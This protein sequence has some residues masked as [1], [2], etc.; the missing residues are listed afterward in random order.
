MVLRIDATRA[1]ASLLERLLVG[2]YITGQDCVRLS[3]RGGLSLPQRAA[4]RSV[5]DRLLGMTI[6]VDTPEVVEVENFIDP[7]R[8]EVPRLIHRVAEVLRRELKVC[9][10]VLVTGR[11]ELLER[12]PPMEAE[13]DQLTLLVTRQLLLSSDDS[14]IAR[15]IDVPSRHYQFGYRL[16]AK[17]LEVI[18][19]RIETIAGELH[20]HLSELAAAPPGAKEALRAGLPRFERLLRRSMTAFAAV[21]VTEADALLNQIEQARTALVE[22][23]LRLL[24]EEPTSRASAAAQRLVGDLA[25]AHALLVIVNEV[26]INRSVEPETVAATGRQ[27]ALR[28]R[29]GPHSLQSSH[30]VLAGPHFRDLGFGT[31]ERS[32]T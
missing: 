14:R 18:G 19:D 17:V 4:I 7:G 25:M 28:G 20:L 2:S 9:H 16:V 11:S 32:S 1:R 26:T 31:L 3:A 12:I 23:G 22:L 29:R 15:E 6:V 8:H 27:V 24:R 10:E 21:S 13:V 30:P 5:V